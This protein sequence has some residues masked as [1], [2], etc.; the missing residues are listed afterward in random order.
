MPEVSFKNAARPIFMEEPT[1]ASFPGVIP[2]K[3]F[4]LFC[5]VFGRVAHP[6]PPLLYFT[7][8]MSLETNLEQ[9]LSFYDSL[10]IVAMF[11]YICMKT[12]GHFR[13]STVIGPLFIK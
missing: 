5:E 3:S 12:Q 4:D 9:N 1:F 7:S 11:H 6:P 10:N 13:L 2:P 8:F